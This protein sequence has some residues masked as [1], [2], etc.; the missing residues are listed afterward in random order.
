MFYYLVIWGLIL[1]W[2][3]YNFFSFCEGL[4]LNLF[5]I[6]LIEGWGFMKDLFGREISGYG[7][8]RV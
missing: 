3:Y 4:N 5:I 7:F 8:K 2:G 1:G 6:V